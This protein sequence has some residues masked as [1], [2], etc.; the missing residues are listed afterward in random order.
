[1]FENKKNLIYTKGR[2]IYMYNNLYYLVGCLKYL[3]QF[4]SFNNSS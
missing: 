2:Y 3:Y 1:M 4:I